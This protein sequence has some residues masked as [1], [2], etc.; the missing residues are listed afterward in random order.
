MQVK[1]SMDRFVPRYFVIEQSLRDRITQLQAH[2]PIPSETELSQT[3]GVSRMTARAAVTKL[4]AD[5]LLY[6]QPGSGT[7]VAE[8]VTHRRADSLIRFSDDMRRQGRVPSSTVIEARLRPVRTAEADRLHIGRT[9]RVVEVRRVRLADGAPVA[10]E[11]AVFPASVAALLQQDL[12][13]VSVHETLGK[14]G[15]VPTRGHATITAQNATPEDASLLDVDL[16]A[17]LLVEHR[18]ILDQHGRPLEL[19]ES[20]YVGSRFAL[21]VVFDVERPNG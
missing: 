11:C 21:D 19:T 14:L 13:T 20:R 2:D 5:G 10:L 4:V 15:R 16:F 1:D 3:F 9:S 7:F 6:R 18:L 8:P 12:A 17:V